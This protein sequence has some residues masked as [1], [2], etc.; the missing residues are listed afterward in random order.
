MRAA[1]G[2]R[3]RGAPAQGRVGPLGGGGQMT[4]IRGRI[5]AFHKDAR[6]MLSMKELFNDTLKKAAHAFT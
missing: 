4:R 6:M 2:Q 3:K 1:A 5:T